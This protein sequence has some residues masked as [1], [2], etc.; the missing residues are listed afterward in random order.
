M[1]KKP[2]ISPS[3][4]VAAAIIAYLAL[5]TICFHYN[6]SDEYINYLA[7][8]LISEGKMP[9]KD[10]FFSHPPTGILADAAV[11]ATVGYNLIALKL[12]AITAFA[13]SAYLIWKTAGK[14]YTPWT[15]AIATTLFLLSF[16]TLTV[17]SYQSGIELTTLLMTASLHELVSRRNFKAG[18]LLGLS[19]TSGLYGMVLLVSYTAYALWMRLKLKDTI[20]PFLLGFAIVFLAFN[21][22][23]TLLAGRNYIDGVY[24][25]HL[26]KPSA[27]KHNASVPPQVIAEN[28][29][30]YLP[31]LLL[32]LTLKRKKQPLTTLLAGSAAAY[33][34]FIL[35][36]RVIFDYYFI[37]LSPYLSI[38]AAHAIVSST[39]GKG[40]ETI[41][42]AL[43]VAIATAILWGAY[44]YIQNESLR[45]EHVKEMSDYLKQTPPEYPLFGDS[46]I[47]P[48]MALETGRKLANN[49]VDTNIMRFITN[50]EDLQKTL[51]QIKEPFLLIVNPDYAI[52]YLPQTKK[53]A[54]ENCKPLKTYQEPAAGTYTILECNSP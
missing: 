13:A 37:L 43:A 26:N 33:A 24:L 38:L 7:G 16:S 25:Y 12:I 9:Y 41:K 18:L 51:N 52:G 6:L 29:Q 44:G 42:K 46:K 48:L 40:K 49:Q 32:L 17:S 21:A 53:Y 4:A 23:L 34:G 45:F 20:I 39:E 50:T 8:K 11:F 10:F 35:T 31:P 5:K 14:I 27:P 2:Q 28:L 30:L 19:T 22:A 3:G 36:L 54:K 47:T 15:A 1:P